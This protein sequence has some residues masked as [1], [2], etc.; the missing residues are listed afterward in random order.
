MT[1]ALPL[2]LASRPSWGQLREPVELQ[3]PELEEPERLASV[4]P[5]LELARRAALLSRR[6]NRQARS[7]CHRQHWLQ[8]VP[9]SWSP[10]QPEVLM[11][12]RLPP[13]L[14]WRP[15]AVTL[16]QLTWMTAFQSASVLPLFSPVEQLAF[17]QR[18]ASLLHLT[19]QKQQAFG[20]QT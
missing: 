17:L 10:E 5:E 3:R 6:W 11:L 7:P 9:G 15:L 18:R 12:A 8:R 16:R 14:A 13:G 19:F 20:S 2:P 4:L 1:I